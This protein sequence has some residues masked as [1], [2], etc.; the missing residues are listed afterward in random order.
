MSDWYE[1][2]GR[3]VLFDYDVVWSAWSGRFRVQ[4]VDP[5]RVAFKR[6]ST[7]VDAQELPLNWEGMESVAAIINAVF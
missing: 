2:R 5:P 7:K 4:R 1:A 3:G 6:F